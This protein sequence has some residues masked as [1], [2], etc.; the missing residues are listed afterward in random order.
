MKS[1]GY[2]SQIKDIKIYKLTKLI[3]KFPECYLLWPTLRQMPEISQKCTYLVAH[4]ILATDYLFKELAA[5]ICLFICK[6]FD[7]V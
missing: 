7:T 3:N 6:F 4:V 5:L 2:A 1:L